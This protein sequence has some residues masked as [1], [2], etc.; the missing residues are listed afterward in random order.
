MFHF[1]F[2]TIS[3]LVSSIIWLVTTAFTVWMLVDCVTKEPKVGNERMIWIIIIVFV[4]IFGPLV[5]YVVRRPARIRAYG[6]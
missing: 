3:F 2:D 5:Y 6:I 1:L 4:P